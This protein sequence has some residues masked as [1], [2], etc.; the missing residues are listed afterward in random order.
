M[1][2]NNAASAQAAGKPGD[3][4]YWHGAFKS[5][6]VLR[7]R[8]LLAFSVSSDVGGIEVGKGAAAK[9]LQRLS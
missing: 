9:I 8:Y 7:G 1:A 5:L 6:N 2:G 3:E 4:A